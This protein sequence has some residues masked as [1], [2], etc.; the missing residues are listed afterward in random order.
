M[1]KAKNDKYSWT[2]GPN[3]GSTTL[4]SATAKIVGPEAAVQC[5]AR[6]WKSGA[7]GEFGDAHVVD[8]VVVKE[9]GG[10]VKN[11]LAK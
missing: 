6:L 11:K 5:E 3:P 8:A 10:R 1:L 7:E 4:L 9:G 2:Y